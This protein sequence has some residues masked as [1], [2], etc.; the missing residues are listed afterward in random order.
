LALLNHHA[1]TTRTN[2]ENC[3]VPDHHVMVS[4]WLMIAKASI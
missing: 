4:R 1:A 2:A 3:Q